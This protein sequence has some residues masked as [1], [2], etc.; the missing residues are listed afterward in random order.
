MQTREW[1]VLK[2]WVWLAVGTVGVFL[3]GSFL[4]DAMLP[5]GVRRAVLVTLPTDTGSF[6]TDYALS[7]YQMV[8]LA[9]AVIIGI[10]LARSTSD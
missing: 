8:V 6:L 4:I 5:G 10:R 1:A 2:P 3:A 7:I 9:V